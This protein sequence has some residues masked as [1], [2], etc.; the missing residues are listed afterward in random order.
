MQLVVIAKEPRPG[1]S[2]TRLCPPCS[3]DQA[4]AIAEASLSDTLAAV[5]ATPAA[6]HVIALDGHAGPWLPS[7]FEVIGQRSGDLADRLAGVFADCFAVS[8]EPVVVIG[9]DTPQVTTDHL[10]R[11]AAR[12]Q[13]IDR[14]VLG[15]APDG[16]YWLV[17]LTRFHPGAFE[18]VTMSE[19]TTAAQQHARLEACGFEVVVTDELEDVDTAV[20]A[21]RVAAG[22]PGSRFATAV[23]TALAVTV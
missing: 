18:G 10:E 12:L 16:G 17:G 6:R 14:A 3:L 9:M 7:C 20:E 8:A 5:A 22:V 19:S 1:F 15:P 2:K 23:D 11:A 13:G 4:A 21:R